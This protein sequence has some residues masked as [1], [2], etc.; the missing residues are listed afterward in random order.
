MV[1]TPG[2]AAPSNIYDLGYRH[3]EGLRLGRR[4]AMF[5]LYL[6]SLRGAFG[7]G[8][9]AAAKVA[10]AALIFIAAIPA[11]IQLLV[12]ALFPGEAEV[13]AH[14]DYYRVISFVLGLYCAAVAPDI[15]GRDQRNRSL[16]LYFS[17]AIE[18]TDY[19]IAKLAA[20]ASAMLLI[21]LG[22]QLL[23]LVANGLV[24]EDFSTHLRDNWHLLFPIA[25][26]ALVGSAL[27]ASMGIAIASQ[28]SRRAFATVGIIVAFI[29]PTAVA[30]ILV[31]GIDTSATHY[32]VF[33]SPLD[34]LGG[35]S[36]WMFRQP[37]PR[38]GAVAVAGFE[39]W[40]Y[41]VVA[42]VVTAVASL[43]VL[44]RYWSVRA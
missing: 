28:T 31:V 24:A 35:L 26:S 16:T 37:T 25:G 9:G 4:H 36:S 15:A 17:R 40:T 21:T 3:Y 44:R 33:V 23:L 32:G 2:R 22:P 8:R 1:S 27:I 41:L 5:V 13:F 6:E 19:A 43:L 42:L 7:L 34:V 11:L 39:G 38:G 14:H 18:R 12:S 10:P 30:R 29:V 20:M